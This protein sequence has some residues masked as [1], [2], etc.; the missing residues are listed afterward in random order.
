MKR[1]ISVFFV[2]GFVFMLGN[3]VLADDP[4][5][6]IKANGSDGPITINTSDTLS[7][8]VSL[9]AG[10]SLGENADWWLAENT[11]SG[12]NYFDVIGGSWSWESGLSVTY[13]GPLFDLGSTGVLNTSGLSPGT[14]TFYF[15]VDMVM[16]ASL[17]MDQIYYDSVLVNVQSGGGG[18][19]TNIAGTWS[20]NWSEIYCNGI[21]Y[22]GNDIVVVEN[23]CSLKGSGAYGVVLVCKL[24]FSN[25]TFTATCPDPDGRC[26]IVTATGITSGNQ[27]SGTYTYSFGGSGTFN[28][29]KI[30]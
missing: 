4:I 25:N 12:W 7:I 26:G 9:D 16:N 24:M 11:P 27:V 28:G 19:C 18:S 1:F 29:S 14:Y 17:D 5:P 23:D 15:G 21:N 13:Q 6:D 30:N 22:S 3:T 8:N 20:V 2:F 10:S